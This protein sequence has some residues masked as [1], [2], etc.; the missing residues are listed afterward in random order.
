LEPIDFF[1]AFL[2]VLVTLVSMKKAAPPPTVR[3]GPVET[4]EFEPD[5]HEPEQQD[6][7][8]RPVA[9]A[10]TEDKRVLIRTS[11]GNWAYK[12]LRELL[13]QDAEH[14]AGEEE[15]EEEEGGKCWK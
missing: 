11:S 1:A 13:Q 9:T 12:S 15:E 8:Q 5:E 14:S 4:T 10:T 3:Y 2:F 7:A 6:D